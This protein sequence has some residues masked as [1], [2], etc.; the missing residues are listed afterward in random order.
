MNTL[1]KAIQRVADN[2]YV[3]LLVGVALLATS[4]QSEWDTLVSDVMHL[5]FKVQH[6]V[7]LLALFHI[8]TVL[9]ALLK[10]LETARDHVTSIASHQAPG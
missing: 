5:Q 2:Q 7:A 8:L 9:S 3:K 1:S 4:L 10:Q 6:G